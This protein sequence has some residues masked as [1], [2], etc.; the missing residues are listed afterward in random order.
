MKFASSDVDRTVLLVPAKPDPIAVI[1]SYLEDSS[2]LTMQH[3]E[4]P[5][6]RKAG[7][8]LEGRGIENCVHASSRLCVERRRHEPTGRLVRASLPNKTRCVVAK[9]FQ[10]ATNY[11]LSSD[12]LQRQTQ[13]RSF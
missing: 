11:I 8:L 12:T 7:A 3:L 5:S 6:G 13:A 9:A 10:T 2:L 1:K 4:M